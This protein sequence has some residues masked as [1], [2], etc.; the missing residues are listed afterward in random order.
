M[1]WGGGGMGMCEC[2][3]VSIVSARGCYTCVTIPKHVIVSGVVMIGQCIHT[4][5]CVP[6]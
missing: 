3:Y 1:G 5:M 2:V 6:M 4:H